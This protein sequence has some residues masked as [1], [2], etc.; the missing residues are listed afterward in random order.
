M[1]TDV[2]SEPWLGP[3]IQCPL[4]HM[5]YAY[6]DDVSVTDIPRTFYLVVDDLSYLLLG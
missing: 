2:T 6:R 3:Q 1:K 5:F 4:W